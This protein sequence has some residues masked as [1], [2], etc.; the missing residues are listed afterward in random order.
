MVLGV[1][2]GPCTCFSS[3]PQPRSHSTSRAVSW[4][5]LG[6][7]LLVSSAEASLSQGHTRGAAPGGLQPPG[8]VTAAGSDRLLK[9]RAQ[10]LWEAEGP[11][12]CQGEQGAAKATQATGSSTVSGGAAAVVKEAM[13]Q[14]TSRL[15]SS[16][17]PVPD[18]PYS[19]QQG[20]GD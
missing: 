11:Q 15:L 19:K 3:D 16:G 2:P 14:G 20:R 4:N 6:W 1:E 12:P 13:G 8:A 17:V 7:G 18:P 9:S 5:H 10:T